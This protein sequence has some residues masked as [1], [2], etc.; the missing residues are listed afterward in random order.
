[1]GA[2]TGAFARNYRVEPAAPLGRADPGAHADAVQPITRDDAP[3]TT[4]IPTPDAFT[5][6]DEWLSSWSGPLDL[7]DEVR[8]P[9]DAGGSHNDGNGAFH[10]EAGPW[11]DD[12]TLVQYGGHSP[13]EQH[14]IQGA[15]HDGMR[16][17]NSSAW[18]N[19]EG[20][21]LGSEYVDRNSQRRMGSHRTRGALRPILDPLVM[22]GDI[23]SPAAP[24]G[25]FTSPYDPATNV[26]TW[27]PQMPTVRRVLR[28]NGDTESTD[29][30]PGYDAV[31]YGIGG[32][33]SL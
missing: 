13:A 27:G 2:Y 6:R 26:R 5:S 28:P 23:P 16:G 21:N 3:P 1:M 29:G 10:V 11:L 19:P 14:G 30:G 32:G 9:H 4:R 18:A 12:A 25:R 22:T 8:R 20:Y 7:D 33:F 15:A 24:M 31:T 17:D